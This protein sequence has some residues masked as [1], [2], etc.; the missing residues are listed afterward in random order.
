MNPRIAM[1]EALKFIL[2]N[3]DVGEDAI[4]DVAEQMHDD[5]D[6]LERL[7]EVVGEWIEDFGENY[8]I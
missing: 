3:L 2:G 1:K 6:F 8:G 4:D 7:E 5:P